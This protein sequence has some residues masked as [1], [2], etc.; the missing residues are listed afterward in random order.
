MSGEVPYAHRR[1]GCLYVRPGG[2]EAHECVDPD[3]HDGEPESPD[4]AVSFATEYKKGPLFYVRLLLSLR[5][6]FRLRLQTVAGSTLIGS[7]RP[8]GD[9][10]DYPRGR[11]RDSVCNAFDGASMAARTAEIYPTPGYEIVRDRTSLFLLPTSRT[12]LSGRENR[13]YIERQER[14]RRKV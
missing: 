14:D 5:S 10:L 8:L 13:S 3:W 1:K 6:I 7:H 4:K 12:W 2:R 11:P 9:K